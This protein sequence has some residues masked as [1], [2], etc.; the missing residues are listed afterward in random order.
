[1]LSPAYGMPPLPTS[2]RTDGPLIGAELAETGTVMPGGGPPPSPVP[3]AKIVY[4]LPF[5]GGKWGGWVTVGPTSTPDVF[6][7]KVLEAFKS[8]GCSHYSRTDYLNTN[9]PTQTKAPETVAL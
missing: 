1:M 4:L 8:C 2:P 9:P 5:C 3:P 7:T 6:V